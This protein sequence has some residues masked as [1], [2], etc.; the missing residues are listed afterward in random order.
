[1]AA[2]SAASVRPLEP[3]EYVRVTDPDMDAPDGSTLYDDERKQWL[4]RVGREWR[5][6]TPP[7]IDD[8]RYQDWTS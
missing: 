7:E 8:A 6:A 1:M 3:G 4:T 2:E 5:I